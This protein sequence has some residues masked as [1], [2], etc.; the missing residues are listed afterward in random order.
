MNSMIYPDWQSFAYK[1]QGREED[2]FE[3]LARALFRKEMGIKYGLFQRVN[4]KGNETDVI[5]KDGKVIGFQSKYFTNG[6]NTKVII[7]SMK[8]AKENH[9]EQK[10]IIIYIATLPLEP[11]GVEK[12]K[13]RQT[14]CLLSLN[15]K[16][17]L[18]RLQSSWN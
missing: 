11:P 15:Q 2:A 12:G 6:I 8:G 3:D 9:P 1:Y 14:P 17:P 5:E 4:H 7:D 18:K 16:S 10:R 13:R